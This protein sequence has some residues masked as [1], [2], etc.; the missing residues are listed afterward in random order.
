MRQGDEGHE[1]GTARCRGCGRL[2][3]VILWSSGIFSVRGTR[4]TTSAG[5]VG[6]A[7]GHARAR[8]EHSCYSEGNEVARAKE[9]AGEKSPTRVL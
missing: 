8:P 3:C 9:Q 1:G 5:Q 7:Y 2:G 6:V 4:R